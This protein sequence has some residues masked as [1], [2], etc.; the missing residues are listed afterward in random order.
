M[1]ATEAINS[2]VKLLG[3]Q[4]KSEKF[5]SVFLEDGKTEVTNNQDADFQVGQELYIVEGSTMK[6]APAGAHELSNGMTV[7]LDENSTIIAIAETVE[8]ESA[9]NEKQEAT[10]DQMNEMKYTEAVD[11]EGQTLES[12]TFD[13][14]ENCYYVDKE[15]GTK[16]PCPDGEHEVILKDESG[17]ENKIRITVKDGKIVQRENVEGMMKPAKM[18]SDF[19]KDINDIKESMSQLLALIGKMDEKFNN[20]VSSIKTDFASFKKLPDRVPVSELKGEK[21]AVLDYKLELIKS[22]RK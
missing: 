4:F 3:L 22:F 10:G 17:N 2:I 5:A 16:T 14:G 21:T 8:D 18:E 11:A 13:V 20:E 6:P 12:P 15:K 9:E 7:S 19:S 1:N